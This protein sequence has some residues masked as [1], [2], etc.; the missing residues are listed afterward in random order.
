MLRCRETGIKACAL[1][2]NILIF[3]HP[4]THEMIMSGG[5]IGIKK[6]TAQGIIG[7]LLMIAVCVTIGSFIAQ[8]M[9]AHHEGPAGEHPA[10]AGEHAPAEAAPAE[11]APAA[12]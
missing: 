6:E 12:P 11:A 5:L 8:S 10:A 7:G 4:P 3:P 1:L 2:T 9:P